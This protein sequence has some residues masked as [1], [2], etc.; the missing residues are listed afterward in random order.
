M[1]QNNGEEE[2]FSILS[3]TA[4]TQYSGDNTVSD[5]G[6]FDSFQTMNTAETQITLLRKLQ[7]Q[8][9]EI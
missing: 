5:N 8:K 6:A 3:P 9:L 1:N 2:V 4:S 7:R